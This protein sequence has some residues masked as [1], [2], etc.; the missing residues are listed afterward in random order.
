M[1]GIR[2]LNLAADAHDGIEALHRILEDVGDARRARDLARNLRP[3]DEPAQGEGGQ[4]F[5]ATRLSHE[6]DTAVGGN[7]ERDVAH[8]N[9]GLAF[10]LEGDAQVAD[11]KE[12]PLAA[13][14]WVCA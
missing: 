13:P 6:R 11:L 12:H 3:L 8:G 10:D 14:S 2:L 5:A 7:R 1:A 4:G 9:G